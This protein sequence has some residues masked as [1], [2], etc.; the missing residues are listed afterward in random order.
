[1]T[2]QIKPMLAVEAQLDKIKFPATAQPKFDGIRSLRT[3]AGQV[4]RTL[5]MIPNQFVRQVLDLLHENEDLSGMDGEIVTYTDGKPD[6][7][8][9]VQSKVMSAEGEFDF[10][11]HVFDLWGI[12]SEGYTSRLA[13]ITERIQSIGSP[14]IQAAEAERV[15]D[16]DALKAYD[17]KLVD[18]GW[19]GTIVRDPE[20][21]YK[22]GRSTVNEGK[23]LKLKRFTDSEAVITG[24]VERMHN[25]NEATTDA[26]GHTKRSSAKAGKVPAGDM[27]ALQL[28]WPNGVEFELGTGF[29]LEQRKQFW[30]K[31][32]DM[33]GQTITFQHKDTGPNGK[34]LILSFIAVRYDITAEEAH[35]SKAN[36]N[37]DDII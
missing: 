14:Y 35:A 26:L 37:H 11:F 29:S 18:A 36:R 4:S 20:G 19:E 33:I 21:T 16:L 28:R 25:E 32:D 22:Y 23:L 10:V 34:P 1:M 3:E 7:L 6:T 15:E 24:M 2:K 12:S 9:Q 17:D 27:G 31:R 30:A 8:H 13:K 5:K